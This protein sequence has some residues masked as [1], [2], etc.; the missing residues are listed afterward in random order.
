MVDEMSAFL[1]F[2]C[3]SVLSWAQET[4]WSLHMGLCLL[5]GQYTCFLTPFPYIFHPK[6]PFG[7]FHQASLMYLSSRHQLR[8]LRWL[9][10][11]MDLNS[12]LWGEKEPLCWDSCL[13][14]VSLG[15]RWHEFSPI[16]CGPVLEGKSCVAGYRYSALNRLG[17][18]NAGR[19]APIHLKCLILKYLIKRPG[20][21]RCKAAQHMLDKADPSIPGTGVKG[22][23]VFQDKWIQSFQRLPRGDVLAKAESVSLKQIFFYCL[24][25]KADITKQTNTYFSTPSASF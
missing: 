18:F 9:N 8:M 14:Y 21:G 12:V 17:L 10:Q 16:N 22:N 23:C 3:P 2:L 25:E 15:A 24:P 11:R 5:S 1:L 13:K 19:N 6:A 7:R 4:F 20:M